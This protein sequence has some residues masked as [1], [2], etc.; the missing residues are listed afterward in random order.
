MTGCYRQFEPAFSAPLR[1]AQTRGPL[2]LVGPLRPKRSLR[3]T[4]SSTCHSDTKNGYLL[5]SVFRIDATGFEPA[6]SASQVDAGNAATMRVSGRTSFN[7]TTNSTTFSAL[8]EALNNIIR[9]GGSL[10]LQTGPERSGSVINRP[11]VTNSRIDPMEVIQNP[12]GLFLVFRKIIMQYRTIIRNQ[13]RHC[14]IAFLKHNVC[15]C[16]SD[17]YSVFSQYSYL[18]IVSPPSISSLVY[19]LF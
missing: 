14:S 2:D 10:P 9:R 7:P 17:H 8:V 3:E 13:D 12:L 5:V 15:I 11:E 16:I 1:S 19:L 4:A 18:I 6:A